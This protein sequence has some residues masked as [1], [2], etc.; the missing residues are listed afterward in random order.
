M[1]HAW[2]L[3]TDV[4]STSPI[5][6]DMETATLRPDSTTDAVC[7]DIHLPR[8][9]DSWPWPRRINRHYD[10]AKK[11]VSAWC[12]SFQAFSSEAQKVINKVDPSKLFI[13][14]LV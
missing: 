9:L 10:S 6:A 12:E 5:R 11:A 2:Y 13:Q 8:T 7:I 3:R 4:L 1:H 14:F